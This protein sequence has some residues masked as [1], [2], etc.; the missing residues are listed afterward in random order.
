[1]R[2]AEF[3]SRTVCVLSFAMLTAL[4][5]ACYH[6][7]TTTDLV[8]RPKFQVEHEME[9]RS[10]QSPTLGGPE[11]GGIGIPL[12]ARQTPE[13]PQDI[14]ALSNDSL[15]V[16]LNDLEYDLDPANYEIE[17]ATC[18]HA[19][20]GA[21]CVLPESARVVIQPEIGAHLWKHTT[22]PAHGLIFARI[23]N[24]DTTDRTEDHFQF[25]AKTKVW[26]VVDYDANKR[27][28]SRYFR[29]NYSATAPAVV[30]VGATMPFV[31]C[32]HAHSSN[33]T[34]AQ[35]KFVSCSQSLA[36]MMQ[37]ERGLGQR[38]VNAGP[39]DAATI[40]PVSFRSEV[41]LAPRPTALALQSTW[42]T[43]GSGCCATSP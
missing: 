21:A 16:Y 13:L 30:Q 29:R 3:R 36:V 19:I 31:Y 28:R 15:V 39:A 5:G 38:R 18:H 41:P 4:V 17:N 1:M 40:R 20:T 23:I 6:G 22:I 14:E 10:T 42:V 33:H 34:D 27:L 11:G 12:E 9:L 2:R 7:T 32:E 43:C 25:P 26:W 8:I 37:P 35:A 24:Y